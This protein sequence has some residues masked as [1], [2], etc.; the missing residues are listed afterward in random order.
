MAPYTLALSP[1][2]VPVTG[3][4]LVTLYAVI[5]P[6]IE[7]NSSPLRGILVPTIGRRTRFLILDRIRSI[8]LC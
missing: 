3:C 7:S 8:A 6:E 4:A 5:S 1:A 2:L